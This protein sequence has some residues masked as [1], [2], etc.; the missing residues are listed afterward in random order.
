M[1][2][3]TGND[4]LTLGAGVFQSSTLRGGGGADTL[5]S[6]GGNDTLDGDTGFD[7]Y[8]FNTNTQLNSDTIIDSLGSM[9]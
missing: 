7:T 5:T 2:G 8:V 1:T 4:Q 9:R 3:L 6:G